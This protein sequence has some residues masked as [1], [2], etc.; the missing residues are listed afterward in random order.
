MPGEVFLQ[1]GCPDGEGMWSSECDPDMVKAIRQ[2]GTFSEGFTAW[3]KDSLKGLQRGFKIT[4]VDLGGKRLSP[5][6]QILRGSTHCLV[7][8]SKEDEREAWV[9]YAQRY[10]CEILAV[11]D[12]RLV[13]DVSGMLDCAARSFLDTS[14]TPV[15]GTLVNLDREAPADPYREA[16][17]ALANH[18]MNEVRED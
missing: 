2:K 9:E 13:T 18:L 1:R 4:L 5:N 6:D 12:S 7:L 8:S 10:G 16:V 15:T 17:G 3:V 14:V 11:I